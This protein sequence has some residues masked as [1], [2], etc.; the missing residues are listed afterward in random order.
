MLLLLP[1]LLWS[2]SS[3]PPPPCVRFEVLTAV[4]KMR[5]SEMWRRA[6]WERCYQG[7][8][9]SYWGTLLSWLWREQTLS[10]HCFPA[11][12][13]QG[14]A[15]QKV[16]IMHILPSSLPSYRIWKYVGTRVEKW[17]IV[18]PVF[19]ENIYRGWI[20][21]NNS[22]WFTELLWLFKS[23]LEIGIWIPQ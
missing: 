10:E 3:S 1:L 15:S 4:F 16:V 21:S 19:A 20:Y 13:L 9:D 2:S 6:V 8:G 17:P 5:S 23:L 7:L 12:Y 11:N 14:A 18:K 22:R